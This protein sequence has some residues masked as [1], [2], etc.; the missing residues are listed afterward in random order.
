MRKR[1]KRIERERER[2]QKPMKSDVAFLSCGGLRESS[3]SLVFI[4]PKRGTCVSR[5]YH[6]VHPCIIIF[7]PGQ[8]FRPH[9]RWRT[10][11]FHRLLVLRSSPSTLLLPLSPWKPC[12]SY[13]TFGAGAWLA[14]EMST[15]EEDVKVERCAGSGGEDTVPKRDLDAIFKSG[16]SNVNTLSRSLSLSP[17][18]SFHFSASPFL[19]VCDL[20]SSNPRMPVIVIRH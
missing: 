10:V 3:I 8:P 7:P 5:R 15:V 13:A 14:R 20:P 11:F 9:R 12:D 16:A 6:G 17:S 2:E 19:A 1:N 4:L 18:F